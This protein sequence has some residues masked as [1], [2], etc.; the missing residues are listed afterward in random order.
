MSMKLQVLRVIFRTQG[1]VDVEPLSVADSLRE[2]ALSSP[3]AWE[4]VVDADVV[5]IFSSGC[6]RSFDNSPVVF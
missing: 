5:E 1:R 3:R 2:C 6:P 4:A